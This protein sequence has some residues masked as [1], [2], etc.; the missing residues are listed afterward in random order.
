MNI[1]VNHTIK[2]SKLKLTLKKYLLF[3]NIEV[4][5]KENR[6]TYI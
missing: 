3:T 6:F 1:Y 4:T 5:Y 2:Y